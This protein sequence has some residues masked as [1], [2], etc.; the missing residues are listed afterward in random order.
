MKREAVYAGSFY[1]K[2]DGVLRREIE[3]FFKSAKKVNLKGKLRALVVPHAGYMYSGIVAAA[4]YKLLTNQKKIILI[5]PSHQAY[6]R[7]FAASGS[8]YWSTPL[9]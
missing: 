3:G 5:G 1:P 7:G 2:N 9:G 8:D 6:F 4:G